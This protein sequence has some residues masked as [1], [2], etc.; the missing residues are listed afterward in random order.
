MTPCAPPGE[1]VAV[2][3]LAAPVAR[4]RLPVPVR[5]RSTSAPMVQRVVVLIGPAYRAASGTGQRQED[6][7]ESSG[8]T[9]A[10]KDPGDGAE[11]WDANEDGS[12]VRCFHCSRG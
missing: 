7:Q 6:R 5:G 4:D 10:V 3:P 8:R 9:V 2:L 12:R 1:G 11:K